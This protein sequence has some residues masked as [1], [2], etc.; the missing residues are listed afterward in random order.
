LA[1]NRFLFQICKIPDC[2]FIILTEFENDQIGQGV[3]NDIQGILNIAERKRLIGFF[4]NPLDATR[5]N[6]IL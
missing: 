1:E 6:D 5:K 4:L 3:V 2:F